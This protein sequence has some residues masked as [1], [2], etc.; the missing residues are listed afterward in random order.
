MVENEFTLFNLNERQRNAKFVEMNCEYKQFIDELKN[1]EEFLDNFGFLTSDRGMGRFSLDTIMESL[2]FTMGSIIDCCES[3]CIAD[4]NTLLRKYR[5]DLF[6]CLYIVVYQSNYRDFS[7]RESMK[8]KITHWL[9]NDLANFKI[10]SVLQDIADVPGLQ[11]TIVEYNLKESFDKIGK[12]LNNY[13][14]GNGYIYYN[15]SVYSYEQN[16]LV[17]EFRHLGYYA[18]YFTTVFL[19]LLI[20][21]SPWLVMAEDYIDYIDV[22]A[23]PPDGSQYWVAYCVEKFVKDNISLIDKNCLDYLRKKTIMKF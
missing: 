23:T 19:L 20:L 7:K 1:V 4:A 16:K 10:S 14:H 3:A 8:N 17:D 21:C 12:C 13:V 9:N 15:R 18:R 22:G 5:D 2:E 11:N 6:F